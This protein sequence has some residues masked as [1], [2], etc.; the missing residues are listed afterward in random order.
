MVVGLQDPVCYY[1]SWDF[2]LPD[3]ILVSALPRIACEVMRSSHVL[4]FPHPSKEDNATGLC[5]SQVT[6]GALR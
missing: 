3:F 4:L 5:A 2:T 1:G 6:V